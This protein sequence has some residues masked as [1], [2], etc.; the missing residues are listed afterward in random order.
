M[1]AAIR[2][3][4][5]RFDLLS[6]FSL[7]THLPEGGIGNYG[8]QMPNGGAQFEAQLQQ[9]GPFCRFQK[10][11][12][13]RYPLAEHLVLSLQVLDLFLKVAGRRAGEQEQQGLEKLA[14]GVMISYCR[15]KL[16]VGD[17]FVPLTA[18]L[19]ADEFDNLTNKGW[20]LR[21]NMRPW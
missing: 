9:L 15:L 21:R 17:L 14:H 19:V 6:P 1:T 20:H 12:L 4:P 8:D 2:G 11:P 13:L 3:R 7:R 18:E 5:F 10:N 16:R